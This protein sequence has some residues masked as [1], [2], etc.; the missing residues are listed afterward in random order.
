MG[1]LHNQMMRRSRPCFKTTK[2]RPN[3]DPLFFELQD[4]TF[5]LFESK[6]PGRDHSTAKKHKLE[7]AGG[8]R[9][10]RWEATMHA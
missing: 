9:E 1:S 2:S 5:V 10:C 3:P 8:N 4:R 7:D 6:S